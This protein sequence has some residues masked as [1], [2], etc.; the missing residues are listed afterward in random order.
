MCETDSGV[1]SLTSGDASVSRALIKEKIRHT[2]IYIYFFLRLS[3]NSGLG[4]LYIT[5]VIIHISVYY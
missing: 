1:T 2:Y 5:R 4:V 3:Q